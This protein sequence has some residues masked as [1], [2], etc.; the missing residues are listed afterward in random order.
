MGNYLFPVFI[1]YRLSC[2]V[3]PF[4]LQP[5]SSAADV[6]KR[7]EIRISGSKL[8]AKRDYVTA[9]DIVTFILRSAKLKLHT[10]P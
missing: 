8:T 6:R 2:Y 3:A 7:V 9:T 5:L 1:P 4:T 10:S